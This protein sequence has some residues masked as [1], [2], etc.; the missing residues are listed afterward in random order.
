MQP[1]QRLASALVPR[2]RNFAKISP[3]F[4]LGTTA[5]GPEA[6][7]PE[8]RASILTT[9]KRESGPVDETGTRRNP[10][11]DK[12]CALAFRNGSTWSSR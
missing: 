8:L 6:A 7:H 5:T 11:G 9:L 1:E 3:N 2:S 10:E 12:R 4:A